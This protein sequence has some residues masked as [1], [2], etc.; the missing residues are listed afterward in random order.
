MIFLASMGLSGCKH[1]SR[2]RPAPNPRFRRSRRRLTRGQRGLVPSGRRSAFAPFRRGAVSVSCGA[3]LVR[4][5]PVMS[6]LQVLMEGVAFGESPRWHDGRLWFS[7]W[8]AQEVV[9]V[10]EQGNRELI[11]RVEFPAFPMCIDFA[12]DGGFWSSPGA[13][14]SCCIASATGHCRCMRIS[15]SCPSAR[16]MTSSSMALAMRTWTTSG[17][18][19]LEA[20]S[21]RE[22]SRR[23]SRRHGRARWRM[24]SRSRTGSRSPPTTAR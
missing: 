11:V 5:E 22:R 21:H 24:A 23:E 6:G 12:G 2:R 15:V 19:S 20:R 4:K 16:G 14:A 1:V 17:S 18:T 8:G 3:T 9:A 13:T 7:D 10:D